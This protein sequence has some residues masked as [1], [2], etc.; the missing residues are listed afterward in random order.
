ML[1]PRFSM[2]IKS[3]NQIMSVFAIFHLCLNSNDIK[4]AVG[5]I[6]ERCDMTYA[7]LD[8]A[9]LCYAPPPKGAL[10]IDAV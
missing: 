1:K 9:V 10:S 4:Q 3:E 8:S 5:L 2:K 6:S 7:S